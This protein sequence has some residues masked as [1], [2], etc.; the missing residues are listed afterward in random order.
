MD[1]VRLLE[2]AIYKIAPKV[3]RLTATRAVYQMVSLARI[4]RD[5]IKSGVKSL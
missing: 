1:V 2:R 4:G 3:T 5:I